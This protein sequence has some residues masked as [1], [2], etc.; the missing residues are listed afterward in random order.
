MAN[1]YA[2]ALRVA[3]L[4]ALWGS[5]FLWIKIGL[6]GFSPI[7]ITVLRMALGAAALLII[8]RLQ[9]LRLP[10]ERSTW[11]H[12][13]V[14]ALFGNTIPYLLFGIGEQ[15]V[16]SAAAGVINAS[17]PL[18]T[19]LFMV[20]AYRSGRAARRN[21]WSLT[22]GFVGVLLIFSPWN[23]GADI[24][25]W[26]GVACLAAAASYGVSYVYIGHFLAKRELGVIRMAAGQLVCATA[27]SIALVPF[28]G[29]PTPQ[30]EA[31][32][33]LAVLV[34]GVLGTGLAYLLN[35]RI[36]TD[37]GPTAA[38]VV[39]YLLPVVSVILGALVLGEQ[40]E[41]QVLAGMAV[42]LLAAALRRSDAQAPAT[43]SERST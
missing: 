23:L 8:L 35:Y 30:F 9:R 34:L 33:V 22:L 38:S 11:G 7:Q 17:T 41:F 4:A 20:L 39:V 26:G 21:A 13:L 40:L 43:G 19:V 27:L 3:A 15:T 25:S 32:P 5:G 10:S 14:A 1:R 42:V 2:G 36:I 24:A 16:S 12:L 18:W 31:G 29:W 37:D 6:G 28:L